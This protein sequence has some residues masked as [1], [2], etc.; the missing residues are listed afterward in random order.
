MT[1][2]LRERAK[3]YATGPETAVKLLLVAVA[4]G[5]D[6]E[7]FGGVNIVD[8]VQQGVA[9]SGAFGESP[10]PYSAG[11]AMVALKRSGLDVPEPLREWMVG[12]Q[13]KSGGWSYAKGSDAD[14]DNTALAITGLLALGLPALDGPHA[15]E[16]DDGLRWAEQNQQPD[17]HWEGFSPVNSTAI[18]TMAL[19]AA[20][21]DT[22]AAVEWLLGQQRADGGFPTDAQTDESDLL[23]TA[24][25]LLA[26]TR[27]SYLT[28]AAPVEPVEPTAPAVP[29]CPTVIVVVDPGDLGGEPVARCASKY[30]TGLEA[31]QDTFPVELKQMMIC[32][33]DDKP[34]ACVTAVDAYWSYWRSSPTADGHS[35][36][37]Y[38][39]KGADST[40]P[41]LGDVEGWRF[42][43]GSKTPALTPAAA[44]QAVEPFTPGDTGN[45]G[46]P[47][48]APPSLGTSG[49]PI[50][51]IVAASVLVL[52]VAALGVW[53]LRRRKDDGANLAN[54]SATF[55]NGDTYSTSDDTNPKTGSIDTTDND[56]TP[57]NGR[58]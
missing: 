2:F 19:G 56:P 7:D 36:W 35:E 52:A 18:L 47:N 49:D 4:V 45:S 28:V 24:Q 9:A 30:A 37:D 55:A 48:P 31:L 12:Q 53:R 17:G 3:D 25:T 32:R 14:A 51:I 58:S 1:D 10:M 41:G 54:G 40:V 33:I 6:Y 38:S 46:D 57:P 50:G 5:A 27:Q 20:G 13:E 26:L 11:L 29:A 43:D 16:V 8:L 23:V 44:I 15:A 21:V 39:G 22:S 42:G 34:D